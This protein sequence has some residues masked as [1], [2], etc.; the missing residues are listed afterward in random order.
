MEQ[1]AKEVL[2]LIFGHTTLDNIIYDNGSCFFRTPGGGGL[3]AASAASCWC[4]NKEVGLITKISNQF[5][6]NDLEI[7]RHH[8]AM[9]SEGMTRLDGKGLKLWL[10]T[11]DDGYR[12]WVLHND[13]C[14]REAA[15][16]L[17]EDI[18][19]RFLKTAVGSHFSPLPLTSLRSL[20][21]ALPSEMY[22]QVDPHYE[23]FIYEN[24]EKWN[25]ILKVTDV[26]LPSQ[27]EL[28]KFFGIPYDQPEEEIK[29]FAKRLSEMGPGIVV[30]KV[31]EK[32]V[33]VYQRQEDVC[34][35]LPSYAQS[36]KDI[37]GAGD[38]FCGGFLISM[39]REESLQTATIKGL[40][41]SGMKITQTGVMPN[42]Q[43]PYG[44]ADSIYRNLL[45][46]G[47]ISMRYL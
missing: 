45:E 38:S 14:T 20:I 42:F 35:A 21:N 17:P 7:I 25:D 29:N 43:T 34:F 44:K 18:P 27:D 32:G 10:L 28:T 36:V 6:K 8:P 37:T 24:R 33:I 19:Q 40:I 9:N 2:F 1:P 5:N 39:C 12:H 16:P 11:D 47:S 13:S 4:N 31:G 15:S 22:I 30:V 23:Y 46:Q 26:I 3:N 41:S